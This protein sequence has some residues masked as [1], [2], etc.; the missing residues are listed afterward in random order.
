MPFRTLRARLAS[1]RTDP[2]PA[3]AEPGPQTPRLSVVIPV[4]NVQD[5]LAACLD[6][7]LGQGME[8]LEVIAVDDGS[9]DGGPA[10]LAAYA[11]RDPRL[12]VVR[13][14]NAGQGVARNTGVALAT[15]TYL[16]FVDADDLVPE[17]AFRAVVDHLDRSGSDFAVTSVRRVEHGELS[18]TWWDAIVHARDRIGITLDD[19]PDA[20]LD[21]I[22]CNRFF[23]RRF[24]VDRVGGFESGAYED[25]VPNVVA[26]VRA[27]RF[28]VLKRVTYHWRIR[29]DRTSTSQQKAQVGNLRDRVE[30]KRVADELLRAEASPLVHAAWIARVLDND[31]SLF[32]AHAGAAEP[33]YR[34]ELAA[35]LRRYVDEATPETWRRVRVHQKLRTWLGADGDWAALERLDEYLGETGVLPPT[36]VAGDRV[37]VRD[38]VAAV[39]G[40]PV[41]EHLLELGASQTV[42]DVEVARLGWVEAHTL[43]LVGRAFA[44]GVDPGQSP[45][46]VRV[47]LVGPDGARV[48]A[49]VV[50]AEV[51]WLPPAYG[52]PNVDYAQGGFRAALDLGGLTEPGSWQTEVT[53]AR[54][55]LRREGVVARFAPGSAATPPLLVPGRVGDLVLAPRWDPADG[56]A[57]DVVRPRVTLVDAELAGDVLRA[58]LETA[59]PLVR[60]RAVPVGG[61]P[62]EVAPVDGGRFAVTLPDRSRRWRLRGV[63][64]DGDRLP[65]YAAAVPA[66]LRPGPSGQVE[67][68]A[69]PRADVRSVMVVGTSLHVELDGDTSGDVVLAS[70]EVTVAGTWDG[71]TAVFPLTGPATGR[72]LPPGGYAVQLGASGELEAGCAPAYAARLPFELA[73]PEHTVRLVASP[74]ARVLLHPPLATDERGR[75]AQRRLELWHQTADLAPEDVV[76]VLPGEDGRAARALAAQMPGV[77]W[78]VPHLGVAV[79]DGAVPVLERSRAWHRM[80]ASARV[81][82]V[83]AEPGAFFRKRPHQTLVRLLDVVERDTA[84]TATERTA[85]PSPAR[86]ARE[87]AR[88]NRDWDAVLVP[89]PATE[90]RLR[91]ELGYTG[92]VVV[93]DPADDAVLGELT[94]LLA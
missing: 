67:V 78:A 84:S 43:E 20:L 71:D 7:V 47:T 16:T 58:R 46:T 15:G 44:R 50:P 73:A 60:V 45:P 66:G 91:E 35:A 52:E 23:R 12:R 29:E 89:D 53:W 54:G 36:R 85:L 42:L 94:G 38:D 79:P 81:L 22:A 93:G 25:H 59:E 64:E 30:V 32:L 11:E 55:E 26:Y 33:A 74:A 4:H 24:W 39:I 56:L 2:A 83:A 6:S 75:F 69:S 62:A 19:F 31:L 17:G 10:L 3:P 57:L 34:A 63:R 27:E 37:L 68:L 88:R 5:Y 1:R 77:R 28:D 8:R 14:E 65:V 72:A 41:P 13:Q 70:D 87:T 21:V 80:L 51:D 18:R 82:V 40:R 86:V 92:R 76:L 48:E 9:T 61:G 90:A 49:R